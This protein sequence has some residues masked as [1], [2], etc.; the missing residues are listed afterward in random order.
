MDWGLKMAIL[1]VIEPMQLLAYQYLLVWVAEEWGGVRTAY[2]YDLLMRQEMAKALERGE[3]DL[4]KYLTKLDRDVLGDAKRKVDI[5]AQE[6]GRDA[7]RLGQAGSQ[8][9]KPF[10]HDKDKD[11]GK[12]K[13]DGG[14]GSQ[15]G[16]PAASTFFF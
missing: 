8:K 10:T 4:T 16:W 1:Q 5:K 12:G 14:K 7:A 11:K 13:K 9:A 15:S 2:H 6:A 3:A